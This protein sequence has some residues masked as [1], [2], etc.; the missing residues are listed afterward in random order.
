M[1]FGKFMDAVNYTKVVNGKFSPS[2]RVA[3]LVSDTGSRIL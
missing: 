2:C 3:T 1:V